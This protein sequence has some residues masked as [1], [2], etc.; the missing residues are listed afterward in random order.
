MKNALIVV[1]VLAVVLVGWKLLSDKS[2]VAGDTNVSEQAPVKPVPLE[3]QE[4]KMD[5][6]GF[7]QPAPMLRPGAPTQN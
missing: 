2:K 5:E 1:I 6:D 3:K 4:K 7:Q